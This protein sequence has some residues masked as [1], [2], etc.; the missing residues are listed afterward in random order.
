MFSDDP[1]EADSLDDVVGRFVKYGFSPIWSLQPTT[2]NVANR[3]FRHDLG[4]IAPDNRADIVVFED[5]KTFHARIV[6]ING[7]CVAK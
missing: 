5:L 3:L 7:F 1:V 2:F 6:L 4:F